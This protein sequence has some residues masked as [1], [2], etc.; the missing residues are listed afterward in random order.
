[1]PLRA[2][3]AILRADLG[4][5]GPTREML[6]S[7][8][9]AGEVRVLPGGRPRSLVLTDGEMYLSP[10]SPLALRRRAEAGSWYAEE[11]RLEKRSL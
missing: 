4:R 7:M 9:S 1:M 11:D 2:V 5:S 3:V 8:R 10:I 6:Q